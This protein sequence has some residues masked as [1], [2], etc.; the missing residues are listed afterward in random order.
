MESWEDL[1]VRM[2]KNFL[3]TGQES[4]GMRLIRIEQD[5][6]CNDFVKKFVNY[7]THLPNTAGVY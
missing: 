4:L 1:R 2:F 6:S 3:N 5:G 7:S